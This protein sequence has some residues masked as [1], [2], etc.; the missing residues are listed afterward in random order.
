MSQYAGPGAGWTLVIPVQSA[1]RAK[2][3]LVVPAGVDRPGLARAIARDSLDAV[4]ATP[5]VARVVV[6]TADDDLAAECTAAGDHVVR[7]SGRS[8]SEAVRHGVEVAQQ[9]APDVPAAVLPADVP[10]LTVAELTEAL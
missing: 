7:D 10:A 5:A 3:R 6:V 2:S 4:R 9:L 8:L 1:A